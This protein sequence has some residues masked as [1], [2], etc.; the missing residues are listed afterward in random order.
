M[1]NDLGANEPMVM[2]ESISCD[3]AGE[4]GAV[5]GSSDFCVWMLNDVDKF[6]GS[7][8]LI[9]WNDPFRNY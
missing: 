2:D 8:I 7:T 3:I 1:S 5:G 9:P 4:K 6:G